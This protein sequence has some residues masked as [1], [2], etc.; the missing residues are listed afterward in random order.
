MDEPPYD[1]LACGACCR[2]GYDTVEVDDDDPAVARFPELFARG[3]FGRLNLARS[4]PRCACLDGAPGAWKCSIY[5]DRP[6]TCRDVEVGG[7]A[8][9]F[10]RARVGLPV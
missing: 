9:R 1:C 4:G 3:P 10:A 8:C 5:A 7:E 6:Q 2:E